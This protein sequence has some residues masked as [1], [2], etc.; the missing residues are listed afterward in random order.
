MLD[1]ETLVSNINNIY[2]KKYDSIPYEKMQKIIQNFLNIIT[3][4]S[5]KDFNKA[6]K[7][8]NKKIYIK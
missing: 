3:I 2:S 5:I 1:K 6:C 7:E 4:K 8:S